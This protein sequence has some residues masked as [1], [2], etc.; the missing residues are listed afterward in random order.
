MTKIATLFSMDLF[1]E[2]IDGVS[3]SS[4]LGPLLLN[5]FCHFMKTHG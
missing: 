3:I 1:F 4:P 5:I 2:Q